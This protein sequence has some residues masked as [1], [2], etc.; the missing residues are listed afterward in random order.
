MNSWENTEVK[1]K[2]EKESASVFEKAM[3]QRERLKIEIIYI[4]KA[5]L[6]KSLF[7]VQIKQLSFL[8][9]TFI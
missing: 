3:K 9:I 2:Q 1:R 4:L 8:G 5:T 7:Q 6:K